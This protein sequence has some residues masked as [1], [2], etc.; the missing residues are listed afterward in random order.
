MELLERAVVAIVLIIV[1]LLAIY[2]AYL[3][4]SGNSVQPI[5]QQHAEALITSDLQTAY[6]NAIINV[7]SDMQSTYA[8]SWHIVVSVTLNAT[9]PCPSYFVNTYDYPR[10]AFVSTPQ[11]TYTKNC[12]IYVF[13]PGGSF[14]LGSTPVAVAWASTHVKTVADY[15][16]AF[17]LQNVS[18]VTSFISNSSA[19]DEWQMIYSSKHAGYA[20]YATLA[21]INGTLLS[22]YNVSSS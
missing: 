19:G 22:N 8:G 4:L 17:G 2:Y 11:N 13:S 21:D 20:I 14:T 10:F 12:Q 7:T 1:I 16:K 15:I 3:F 9:S 18:V 5:T 6:P